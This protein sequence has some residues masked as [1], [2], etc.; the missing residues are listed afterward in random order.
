MGGRALALAHE[1]GSWMGPGP[2]LVREAGISS[3]GLTHSATMPVLG[4][5]IL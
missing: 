4:M 1:A 2:A 5:A 3:S